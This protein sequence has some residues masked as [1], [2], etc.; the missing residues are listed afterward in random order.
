[1]GQGFI[2]HLT[3]P[4]HYTLLHTAH[5]TLLKK[6]WSKKI[7]NKNE[8]VTKMVGFIKTCDKFNFTILPTF[9]WEKIDSQK[10]LFGRS[11]LFPPAWSGNDKNLGESFAWGHEQK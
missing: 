9:C 11:G 4:A 1:M 3:I 5:C 8:K 10:A 6:L 2:S 7:E